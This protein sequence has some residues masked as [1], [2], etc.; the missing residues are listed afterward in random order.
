[1]VEGLPWGASAR[2]IVTPAPLHDDATLLDA[3]DAALA[4]ELGDAQRFCTNQEA[5][6]M[7]LEAFERAAAQR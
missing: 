6:H 4:R 7:K 3:I 1:M 2:I 5:F